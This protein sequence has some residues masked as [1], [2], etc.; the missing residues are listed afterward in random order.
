MHGL[1]HWALS[2]VIIGGLRPLSKLLWFTYRV[3]TILGFRWPAGIWA[4]MFFSVVCLKQVMP[5][6]SINSGARVI[7]SSCRQGVHHR[8]GCPLAAAE[9]LGGGLIFELKDIADPVWTVAAMPVPLLEPGR[10][11][12]RRSIQVC[13]HAGEDLC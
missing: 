4:Y 5:D 9:G 2:D 6:V 13:A 1:F 3:G 8:L 11:P 7:P 12:S 10:Q